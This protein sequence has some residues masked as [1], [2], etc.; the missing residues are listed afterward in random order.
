[1]D[2]SKQRQVKEQ[3]LEQLKLQLHKLTQDKERMRVRTHWHSTTLP[4]CLVTW[5]AG[6]C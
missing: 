5:R 4:V 3:E 1:V 6:H 2:E